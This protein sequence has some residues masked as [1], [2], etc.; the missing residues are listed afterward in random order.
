[1]TPHKHAN[2][3][4]A[5]ADGAK[6]QFLQ[7]STLTWKDSENPMWHIDTEYRIKP[8]PIVTYAYFGI[9]E[10]QGFTH[11][12]GMY[13][14]ASDVPSVFETRAGK[15]KTCAIVQAKFSDGVPESVRL[16]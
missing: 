7:T 12:T 9:G 11:T 5:W 3:I 6:I 13:A 4:K 14:C 10:G 16:I 2:L 1:M 15:W 8:E